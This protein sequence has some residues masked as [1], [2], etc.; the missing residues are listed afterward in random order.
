MQTTRRIWRRVVP[1]S[2]RRVI[3]RR[4]SGTSIGSVTGRVRTSG[5][6]APGTPGGTNRLHVGCGPKNLM[7]EWWNVDIRGFPGI[8]QVADVT[9]PWPWRNLDYVYGEHFLEHLTLDGAIRFLTEAAGA[10]RTDGRIR[11]ST[12]GLEWV[13]RTHFDPAATEADR[14]AA[15]YKA[16]R[17]FYGWGH[18][19]LYSRP[20]L[21]RVLRGAGFT[22]L[23]FHR[24]GESDDPALCGLERHGAFEVVDSWPNVW[25]VE[26]TPSGTS[27][28][29]ALLTEADYELERYRRQGP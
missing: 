8:D 22:D 4:V 19:F 25:I 2:V 21:E 24:F 6:Q 14:A 5:R 16:N 3:R 1:S 20:M 15:T 26:A 18:Q 28:T 7:D 27:T 13:W 23:T 17:A 10:L 11:L 29:N 9:A 12:P